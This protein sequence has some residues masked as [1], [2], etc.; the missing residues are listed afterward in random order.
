M[1]PR[2]PSNYQV[3]ITVDNSGNFTYTLAT[4]RLQ[5]GDTITWECQTPFTIMFQDEGTPVGSMT[6]YGQ[7]AGPGYATSPVIV[8]ATASGHFHYA[9]AVWSPTDNKVQLDSGCP[10]LVV[11]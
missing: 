5:P 4:V 8:S 11:N 7:S 2:I 6:L 1:H 3:G 9:V 10:D